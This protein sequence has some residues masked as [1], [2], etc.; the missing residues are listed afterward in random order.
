M[1]HSIDKERLDALKQQINE[2]KPEM[3]EPEYE[4]LEGY[5]H[6]EVFGSEMGYYKIESENRSVEINNVSPHLSTL[7]SFLNQY[8][9]H[10][11]AYRARQNNC[12]GPD[13]KLKTVEEII[14]KTDN[15]L[16]DDLE[17]L[18]EELDPRN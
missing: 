5:Q 1:S 14:D 18:A 7:S 2:N 13:T 6:L 16:T 3:P 12:S 17:K 8:N 4:K 15:E 9:R 10:G 11:N